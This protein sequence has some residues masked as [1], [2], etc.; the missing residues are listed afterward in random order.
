MNVGLLLTFAIF[1]ANEIRIS[2]SEYVPGYGNSYI[3]STNINSDYTEDYWVGPIPQDY[4]IVNEKA[5]D[6]KKF[7]PATFKFTRKDSSEIEVY[8]KFDNVITCIFINKLYFN[9]MKIFFNFFFNHSLIFMWKES[10]SIE[11]RRCKHNE[12]F[13]RT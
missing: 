9:L 4:S 12:Y 11:W 6:R 3:Y 2:R 5:I 13:R 8:I 7:E 10:K 1:S